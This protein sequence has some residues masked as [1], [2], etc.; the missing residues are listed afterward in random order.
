V[1]GAVK[2][3]TARRLL[4]GLGAFLGAGLLLMVASGAPDAGETTRQLLAVGVFLGGMFYLGYRF[5]VLPRRESFRDQAGALAFRAE[6]G[7]PLG[8]LD[9]PF[10]LFRWTGSVRAIE[11]T[12]VGSHRGREVAIAD[13]WFSPTA[14]AERDDYERYTCVVTTAPQGWSDL[15][16]VPERLGSR[17]LGALGVRD[18]EL[19]SEAFNRAFHVRGADRRFA[20]AFVDA[21]LMEWLLEQQAV[22]G[23][24]VLDGRL[25]VFRQ[26][27]TL[28]LDDVSATLALFDAFT[29][30]VPRVVGHPS[31]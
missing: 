17:L 26:R 2:A 27:A 14:A 19:E 30:R 29:D 12:A 10:T 8:L 20:S 28:S 23:F 5:R 7:D 16:V 11:N 6:P 22:V 15:V 25:L 24:E 31:T 1:D 9:L 21:R 4:I 18:I 3:T 13:Y